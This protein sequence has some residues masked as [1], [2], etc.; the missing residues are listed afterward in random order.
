MIVLTV[1][2]VADQVYAK[3]V[4]ILKCTIEASKGVLRLSNA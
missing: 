1:T 2:E 3:E 4:E